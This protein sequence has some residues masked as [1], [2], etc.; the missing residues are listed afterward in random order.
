MAEQADAADS[1]SAGGNSMG[2]R[3][4]LPAPIE[5]MVYGNQ[6]ILGCVFLCPNYDQGARMIP[7]VALLGARFRQIQ[8]I[9][10]EPHLFNS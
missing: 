6:R 2:V 3:F 7:L 8:L 9:Q 4:P 5:S 1:K 10:T